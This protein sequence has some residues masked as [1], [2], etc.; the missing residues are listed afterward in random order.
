[1]TTPCG[2][3]AFRPFRGFKWS[4]KPL[5]MGCQKYAPEA[6]WHG[7][8]Q[9]A[10]AITTEPQERGRCLGDWGASR[11]PTVPPCLS[12]DETCSRAVPCRW[13][14]HFMQEPDRYPMGWLAAR[15][16]EL[17][18]IHEGFTEVTA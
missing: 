10:K 8:Y 17:R 9:P 11:F 1:M 3:D 13:K 2:G 15:C 5:C 6:R 7:F 14:A 18:A 12:E 16:D 4:G